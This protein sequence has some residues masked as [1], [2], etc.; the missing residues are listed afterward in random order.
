MCFLPTTLYLL[1]SGLLGFIL[2]LSS[3]LSGFRPSDESAHLGLQRQQCTRPTK[4]I[5][6]SI[7]TLLILLTSAKLREFQAF[8]IHRWV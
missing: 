3:I 1:S 4:G 8:R 2:E 5:H 6:S 7:A